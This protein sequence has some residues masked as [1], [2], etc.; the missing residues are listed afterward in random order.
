MAS[1]CPA[2]PAAAEFLLLYRT[3]GDAASRPPKATP[4]LG[5]PP[6]PTTPPPRGEEAPAHYRSGQLED[7]P[8]E[9]HGAQFRAV[10]IPPYRSGQLEGKIWRSGLSCLPA[11]SQSHLTDLVSWKFLMVR[12]TPR[13]SKKKVAIP[14][15]RS[16][17]LEGSVAGRPSTPVREVAIPPYRSGQLEGQRER[18]SGHFG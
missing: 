3:A 8:G 13:T 2:K 12:M 9:P 1:S 18:S 16:G 7:E 14:P 10:A 4:L 15:Y 5:P 6:L 17:Q 11:L